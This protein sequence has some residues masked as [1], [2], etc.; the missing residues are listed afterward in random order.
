MSILKVLLFALFV[1]S[2]SLGEQGALEPSCTGVEDFKACLGNTDNFCP[3]GISCQCKNEKPFCRC[4]YFRVDWKEY[5]YMGPKCNH[6]WNT[7][8]FILVTILPAVGLVIVVVVIF[9]CVYYSKSEKAGNQTNPLYREAQHNPAFTAETAGNL[10]HVYQQS[11]RDV[12]VGQIPKPVLRRQDFDDVPT[13]SQLQNYSPMHPQPLR[14]PDPATDHF[15]NQRSQYEKFGYPSSNLPYADY[16]EG[17]Q[18]QK[19]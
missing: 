9:Y 6:L 15:S 7:L 13:P 18:Y 14:R 11:P 17:R 5:W 19:Y 10:G 2:D 16:A 4:D 8:D 1:A 12:R 3:T